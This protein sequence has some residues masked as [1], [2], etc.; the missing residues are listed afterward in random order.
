MAELRDIVYQNPMS[1]MEQDDKFA[2]KK[3]QKKKK[4]QEVSEEEPSTAEEKFLESALHSI[5][6]HAKA[7]ML[8]NDMVTKIKEDS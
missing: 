1:V 7:K 4:K 5:K 3:T 6:L 8:V 2:D